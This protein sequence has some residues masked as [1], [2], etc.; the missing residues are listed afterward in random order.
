MTARQRNACGTDWARPPSRSS[1][2]W[3]KRFRCLILVFISLKDRPSQF[4]V[5]VPGSSNR[6]QRDKSFKE[7]EKGFVDCQSPEI[8]CSWRADFLKEMP[9]VL[10]YKGGV[11]QNA[12]TARINRPK[13]S[14]FAPFVRF[15]ES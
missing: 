7:N 12:G 15:R 10:R 4:A 8:H 9:P 5:A 13:Q 11:A 2:I 1:N 6:S 14:S 3:L